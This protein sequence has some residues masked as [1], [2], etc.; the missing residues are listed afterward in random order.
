MSLFQKGCCTQCRAFRVPN[1]RLRVTDS[2]KEWQCR[3]LSNVGILRMSNLLYLSFGLMLF[4]MERLSQEFEGR[5]TLELESTKI[6]QSD[7]DK[8]FEV[9]LMGSSNAY[10]AHRTPTSFPICVVAMGCAPPV[11]FPGPLPSYEHASPA[12]HVDSVVWSATL[13]SLCAN[14]SGCRLRMGSPNRD[15][16]L[17]SEEGNRASVR[18]SVDAV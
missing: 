4:A 13:R 15:W 12:H 1:T 7:G 6:P 17:I 14:L 8:S 2:S 16:F 3:L 5:Y 18:S 9:K 10:S 11:L